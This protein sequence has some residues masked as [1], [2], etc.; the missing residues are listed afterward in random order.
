MPTLPLNWHGLQEMRD[1]LPKLWSR[2]WSP[3]HGVYFMA[4]ACALRG[5]GRHKAQCRVLSR[6]SGAS[7]T[8]GNAGGVVIW[9]MV[10]RVF[11]AV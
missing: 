10:P 5:V 9:K 3:G 4:I 6:A 11:D 7:V 8:F 1:L 2:I